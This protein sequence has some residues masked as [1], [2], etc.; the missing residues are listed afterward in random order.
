MGK[1]RRRPAVP[2]YVIREVRDVPL[3]FLDEEAGKK[4]KEK[5]KIVFKSHGELGKLRLL[6]E[7]KKEGV[8]PE[9]DKTDNPFVPYSAM[10]AKIIVSIIDGDG[11]AL[12][13]ET[14]EP[15]VFTREFFAGM[16]P[17]DLQ[18]IQEAIAGDANPQTSSPSSGVSGSNPEESKA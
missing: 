5:F 16:L 17:E 13:D 4:V 8:I 15:A 18:S 14:G 3:T 6:A 11:E 2:D 10:F 9:E 12:T 7:L 1:I